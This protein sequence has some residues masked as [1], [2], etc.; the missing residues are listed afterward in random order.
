ML[1]DQ[2]SAHAVHGMLRSRN[3]G[4]AAKLQPF[5]R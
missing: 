5:L 2:S 3:P 4:L 1:N